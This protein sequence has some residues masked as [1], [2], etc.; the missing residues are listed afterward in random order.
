MKSLTKEIKLQ[1]Y[2]QARFQVHSYISNWV[3]AQIVLEVEM[4][5][6]YAAWDI[7]NH[8]DHYLDIRYGRDL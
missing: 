6:E 1:V 2:D 7:W 5:V 3:R 8:I 4:C